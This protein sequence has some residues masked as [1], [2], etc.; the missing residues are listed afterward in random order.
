LQYCFFSFI[1]LS[2]PSSEYAW[3]PWSS[4]SRCDASR[5]ARGSRPTQARTRECLD[6]H[7]DTVADLKL[8]FSRR[9]SGVANVDI[10]TCPC[11][12]DAERREDSGPY[13][14]ALKAADPLQGKSRVP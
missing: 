9:H 7:G 11:D 5:C 4:W 2:S 12:G 13:F 1:A 10:R 14:A 8:C 6:R 3:A